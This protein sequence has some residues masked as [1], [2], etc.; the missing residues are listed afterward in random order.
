MGRPWGCLQLKKKTN[1]HVLCSLLQDYSES[2]P[3]MNTYTSTRSICA[4]CTAM[5]NQEIVGDLDIGPRGAFYLFIS[6]FLERC[7]R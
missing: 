3:N 5:A 2:I 7:G 4:Q 1:E 6:I